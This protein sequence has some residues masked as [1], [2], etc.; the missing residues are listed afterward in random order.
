MKYE[1]IKKLGRGAYGVVFEV[2]DRVS[3]QTL[4]LKKIFDAFQNQTDAQRTY[5]EVNYLLNFPDSRYVV[6][7]KNIYKANNRM[8]LYLVFEYFESDLHRVIR[9]GILRP[10]HFKYIA[11]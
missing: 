2:R 5:R 3:R 9:S 8:D 7:L 6:N 4:V 11:Y 1:V 10:V